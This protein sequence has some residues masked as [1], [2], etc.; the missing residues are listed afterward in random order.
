[1]AKTEIQRI[2]TALVKDLHKQS[3]D[4]L[5]IYLANLIRSKRTLISF[6][7]VVGE[8]IELEYDVS[9][10]NYGGE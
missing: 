8:T 9:R 10:L 2:D 6:K 7:Y 4:N 5:A 3:I 1:M